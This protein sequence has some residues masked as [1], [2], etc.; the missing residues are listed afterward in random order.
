[1]NKV[2]CTKILFLG[3]SILLI[4]CNKKTVLQT[5]YEQ[6]NYYVVEDILE[7]SIENEDLYID[8][9]ENNIVYNKSENEIMIADL[10]GKNSRK[11][12]V[13]KNEESVCG[14]AHSNQKIFVVKEDDDGKDVKF[15]MAEVNVSGE[16]SEQEN[17]ISV[18]PQ[19]VIK[20]AN[21]RVYV[22][23]G[24]GNIHVYDEN[25]NSEEQIDEEGY[26][27]S[28]CLDKKGHIL[29]V[30]NIEEKHYI[31]NID[32]SLSDSEN[33]II[34]NNLT[35]MAELFLG[36]DGKQ[37]FAEDNYLY[38]INLEKE[39]TQTIL[40]WVDIGLSCDEIKKISVSACGDIYVATESDGKCIVKK[41][42]KKNDASNEKKELVLA[43]IGLDSNL[44]EQIV[45][46]NEK[47]NEY[48]ISIRD[49]IEEEY[50]YQALDMD[51]I[52]GKQFDIVSLEGLE[53][54]NYI[55]KGLLAD[56]TEYIDTD[57]Y[58][59][60]Y[61]K[62]VS[63]DGHIYQISPYFSIKTILGKTADV[64]EKMSWTSDEMIKFLTENRKT[65]GIIFYD[66]NELLQIFTSNGL[67]AYLEKSING[68]KLKMESLKNT[69]EFVNNY[70]EYAVENEQDTIINSSDMLYKG[71][72]LLFETRIS[73]GNDYRTLKML[74][75]SDITAKGYPTATETGNYIQLGMPMGI[76]S[77]SE[78]KDIC[79]DFISNL[80]TDE[81][82]Y[83]FKE[84]GFPVN[85][86]VLSRLYNEWGGIE[87]TDD[88]LTIEIGGKDKA[89]PYLTK[90]EIEEL[91]KIL[92]SSCQ[93]YEDSPE[94]DAI[95]KEESERF[96]NGEQNIDDTG[97]YIEKRI[98]TYL[99]ETK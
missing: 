35:N 22:L 88:E 52:S 61:M 82:Q 85:R 57:N 20:D 38:S 58:I 31:E 80:L 71:D 54:Q 94:M 98:N 28:L 59:S 77:K 66:E 72:L 43:C 7:Y 68:K 3:L 5:D 8:I 95:M 47:S 79:W 36:Y 32:K 30:E 90:K 87:K 45:K 41:I 62:A 42:Y 84:C 27:K 34:F 44:Q 67:D 97:K 96:F 93:L 26:V 56:L 37:Y 53:T 23:S 16:V 12:F 49:Y 69:L 2:V 81:E 75:R 9:L 19:E 11:L 17:Q 29:I 40:R 74:F 91:E 51:I 70:Q 60:A 73:S 1:M 64:G 21:N 89:I 46:F 4:G 6:D 50:P 33:K 14:I 86:N 92:E 78:N 13:L 39:T 55:N 99:E 63:V 25:K 15:S 76:C 48:R 83:N 24:N 10:D 18:F 65:R